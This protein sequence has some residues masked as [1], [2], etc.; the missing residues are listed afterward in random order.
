M[1]LTYYCCCRR[2][3]KPSASTTS[4]AS[5]KPLTEEDIRLQE[6]RTQQLQQPL[7][8]DESRDFANLVYIA[9]KRDIRVTIQKGTQAGLAAGLCVMGGVI[10]K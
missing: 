6:L 2:K 8:D 10:G 9:Q 4:N 3:N 7:T 1:C 5:G